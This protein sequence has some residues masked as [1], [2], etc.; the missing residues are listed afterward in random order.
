MREKIGRKKA[1]FMKLSLSLSKKLHFVKCY[2]S[3]L[4]FDACKICSLFYN[5]IIRKICMIVFLNLS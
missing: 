4:K 1:I 3:P 5:K 2:T